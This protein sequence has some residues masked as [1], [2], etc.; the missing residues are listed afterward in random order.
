MQNFILSVLLLFTY[1]NQ[2]F[3]WVSFEMSKRSTKNGMMT[4]V[5]AKVFYKSS[6]EMVTHFS[7]PV[8]MF[9]LNNSL[10]DVQIYNPEENEVFRSLDN[11]LGSQNNTF[12]YF[13]LGNSDDMGLE[14]SGF[15]LQNSR[16]EDMMLISEWSPPVDANKQLELVELV[17]NGEYPA[18]MGYLTKDGSYIKKIFYYDFDEVRESDFPKSITEIDYINGDSVVTKTSFSNFQFDSPEDAELAN[19]KVPDTAVLT[20]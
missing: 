20:K 6:G 13:L 3:Q 7:E 18:F 11:R 4:R 16:V 15:S 1:T 9:V 8:E 5:D 17:S 10:G 2:D 12:Y 19:Y 14:E